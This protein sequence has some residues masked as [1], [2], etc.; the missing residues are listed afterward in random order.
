MNNMSCVII[1]QN[2]IN[3]IV[4]VA[5]NKNE[6]TIVS[7]EL[8]HP[9]YLKILE[10]S[11]LIDS[12]IINIIYSYINDIIDLEL[13]YNFLGVWSLGNGH[14]ASC[15]IEII[16]KDININFINYSFHFDIHNRFDYMHDDDESKCIFEYVQKLF[17]YYIDPDVLT[18]QIST[19]NN[20]RLF[21]NK[22]NYYNMLAFSR[23]LLSNP[24]DY[25]LDYRLYSNKH[26]F[27]ELF[28]FDIFFNSYIRTHFNNNELMDPSE[29][30][31]HVTKYNTPNN[32]QYLHSSCIIEDCD[33]NIENKCYEHVRVKER[34]SRL[35]K[36]YVED[37]EKLL[38]II[39]IIRPICQIIYE[40][41]KKDIEE[42]IIK[43]YKNT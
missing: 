13:K 4:D 6:S 16:A 30:P 36:H 31:Q 10:D 15:S 21:K 37:H 35:I 23:K 20:K 5:V 19:F 14:G 43:Y 32:K 28:N 26:K 41:N 34:V 8:H 22:D 24:Q 18:H 27:R 29:I 1:D 25:F 17:C 12:N 3:K 7:I 39:K 42:D 38:N 40:F 33:Y 11:T 2:I 9:Q